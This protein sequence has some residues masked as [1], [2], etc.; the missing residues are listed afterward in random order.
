VDSCG[1]CRVFAFCILSVVSCLL[2]SCDLC[3]V[4]RRKLELVMGVGRGRDG[5]CDDVGGRREKQH[6]RREVL[7]LSSQRLNEATFLRSWCLE[8]WGRAV[9]MGYIRGFHAGEH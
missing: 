3:G 2:V 8:V 6:G 1:L 9:E 5:A 7:I 4:C